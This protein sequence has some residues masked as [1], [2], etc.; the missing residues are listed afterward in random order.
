ML[1]ERVLSPEMP[2]VCTICSHVQRDAIERALVE[3]APKRRIAAGFGV[4]EQALRRHEERHLPNTLTRASEV[5]EVIRADD[6]LGLA[7]R[8]RAEPLDVLERAKAADNLGGVLQAIDQ[9]QK[10]VGLLAALAESNAA[11]PTHY[12]IRRLRPDESQMPTFVGG[13]FTS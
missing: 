7:R 1:L 5:R 11:R 12:T 4:T 13:L 6:L 10:G 8:L 2:R 9:L 3:S